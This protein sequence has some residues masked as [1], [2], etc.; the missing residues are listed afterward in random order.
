MRTS[1]SGPKTVDSQCAEGLPSTLQSGVHFETG[2]VI[3]GERKLVC[4]AAR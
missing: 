4:Y 2:A 3:S 1:V